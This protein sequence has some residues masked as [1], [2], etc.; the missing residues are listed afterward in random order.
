MNT[1]HLDDA[2]HEIICISD[3]G[4]CYS[5]EVILLTMFDAFVRN[6]I[7]SARLLRETLENLFTTI[8]TVFPIRP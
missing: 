2:Y 4:H 5:G 6:V 8:I 1:E 3:K 7:F